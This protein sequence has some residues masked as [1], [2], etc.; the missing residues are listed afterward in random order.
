MYLAFETP[1]VFH[2]TDPPQCL[3]LALSN[4]PWNSAARNPQKYAFFHLFFFTPMVLKYIKK[5]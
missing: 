5:K 1:T 2:F 3:L 4:I